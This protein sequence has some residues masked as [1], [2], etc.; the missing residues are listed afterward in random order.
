MSKGIR[1]VVYPVKD[2]Q[3]A[4]TLFTK[5]LGVEPYVDSPYYV[6]YKAGDIDIG[7][8]PNGHRDGATVYYYVEDIRKDL[9]ALVDSG[10]QVIQDVKDIGGGGQ[11][12]IIKDADENVVGLFHQS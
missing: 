3:K 9:Q 6:G 10:A 4:K 12:A 7:L 1:N 2:V 5:L 8:D 11:I